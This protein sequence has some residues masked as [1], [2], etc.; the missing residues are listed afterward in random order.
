MNYFRPE[1]FKCKC[2]KC[3]GGSMDAGLVSKLN[4]ARHL[5][6]VP[7]NITSA[8]RC[9]AHNERVGGKPNSAHLR[10]LAVDISFKDNTHAFAI[11][12]ALI[13]VGFVRIGYNQK[14]SFFH[15]DAD[16]SLPQKVFFNY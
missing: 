11:L 7:F 5:A 9:A 2:G 10:G 1:E 8:Y 14:H 16:K 12:Q 4:E 6:Q 13:N 15:V 3:S